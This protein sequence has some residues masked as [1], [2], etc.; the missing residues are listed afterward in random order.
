M[1]IAVF[2]LGYVGL[3]T[4]I[5]FATKG[6]QVIGVDIDEERV[7][8]INQGIL[9]FYEPK[10]N[11]YLLNVLKRGNFYATSNYED[12]VRNTEIGYICVPTPTDN[13]GN[14][15]LIYLN[16]AI[17]RI[18]NLIVGG[19]KY[20][21]IVI[22]STMPPS[23]MSIIRKIIEGEYGLKIGDDVGLAHVPEFLRTG[24]T[25][26]DLEAPS[27]V[28]IGVEDEKT[29][30][31]LY[32]FYKSLYGDKNVPIILTNFVN[33]EFIKY[34]SNAFL[35]TKISFIN[36]IARLAEKLEGADVK[37]IAK[38]IGLDPRIGEKF[39]G[40][41]LGFGGSCLPKDLRGFVKTFENYGEKSYVL[42]AAY[43]VNEEQPL[44]GVKM[45][46]E[47]VGELKGKKIAILGASFKPNTDDI[48]EAVSI[49]IIN[50]L[51]REGAN[52][53]VYDPK[54]LD[55][56]KKVFGEK[57]NYC[58]NLEEVLR[59]AHGAIVVT[60]WE[61]IRRL[62]P[63]KFK[64]LMTQPNLVDGRRIYDPEEFMEKGIRFRAIGLG[65]R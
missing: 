13:E 3:S 59:G 25:L 64:E 9:P 43:K 53:F 54:A 26:S 37:V 51:I 14:V 23:T 29:R 4:G 46:K 40:A 6:N 49:E 33:A 16:Q 55:N 42:A 10:L 7:K 1:R 20:Y 61:E 36:E 56:L 28:V 27:R 50:E 12:A 41:G 19:N 65:P 2:G 62:K 21:T 17:R 58:G 24:T 38:G 60:E 22:K 44:R 11:D 5:V 18:L 48:R 35:S 8:K 52:V 39:L 32:K 45:L 47:L 34:T 15:N 31:L 30:E 57:I 63:E